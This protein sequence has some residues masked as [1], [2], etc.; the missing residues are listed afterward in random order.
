MKEVPLI[1]TLHAAVLG[2]F[3]WFM[4]PVCADSST[5]YKAGSDFAKQVQGGGLDALKNFNGEQTLPGYTSR[6]DQTKYYGGV[7]A[8]GDSSLKRDSASEFSQNEAGQSITES[9]TNRPPDS[10]SADAPFIQAAQDTE[11]RADSIVGDTGQACKAQVV[12]RSEFTNHTCERD[13]QVENFCTREATLK[14]NATTQKVSRTYQQAVPMN[15]TRNSTR[16]SGT[17]TIPSTGRLL[18][19]SVDG[20]PL[21]VPWIYECDNEGKVRDSCKLAVSEN[22]SLFDKT[23]PV[24]VMTW[25]NTVTT[26]SGGQN[27]HCTSHYY[28]GTGKI[29]QSFSMDRNVV[30]GQ[31]FPVTKTSKTQPSVNVKSIQ[32]TVILVMEETETVFAPEVVWVESCPFSKDEGTKTGEECISPGGTKTLNLGGKAYS[33]T[34][35]CWKYKDTWLTQP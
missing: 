15:F 33:F 11:S 18:S 7:T 8:S 24:D 26:C 34:E 23:F 6:P 22:I 4:T 1:I 28:D 14:H 10:I 17:L 5:D 13:L 20:E 16:W 31:I 21:P 12:N 27:T 19:V 3:I 32:V 29:H 25:P 9:F 2:T 35:A 30:A